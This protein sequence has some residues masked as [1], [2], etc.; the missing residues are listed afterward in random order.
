[1]MLYLSLPRGLQL[2]RIEG[3]H[4]TAHDVT[5]VLPRDTIKGAMSVY[6]FLDVHE[7]ELEK[8]M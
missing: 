3:L 2:Y 4:P 8:I 1:M 6:M 7:E 5:D